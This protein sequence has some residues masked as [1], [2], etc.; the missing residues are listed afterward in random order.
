MSVFFSFVLFL[1]PAMAWAQLPAG[2]A[3]WSD[4]TSRH[5][6]DTLLPNPEHPQLYPRTKALSIVERDYLEDL[7][8]V[9]G[10]MVSPY[11][12]LVNFL[13]FTKSTYYY[14]VYALGSFDTR[15]LDSAH[16][17][18]LLQKLKK[19]LDGRGVYIYLEEVPRDT[20]YL[21]S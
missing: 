1:L 16:A 13:L 12:S 19:V 14:P 10:R 4:T 6:V 8:A 15:S 9:G 18:L 2:R 11:H 7:E 20:N 5:L 17:I 21:D 3:V